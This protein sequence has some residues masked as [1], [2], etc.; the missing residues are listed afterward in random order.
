MK[1]VLAVAISMAL[2]APAL[3]VAQQGLPEQ[4]Q[5]EVANQK[6]SK[7]KPLL[8]PTIDVIGQ[9]LFPYQEGI[10]IDEQYV[11]SQAK[12]NGDISTLLRIN[13]SVQFS[14]RAQTSANMGEIRPADI[15]INGGLFYQNNFRID[16]V[17]FSND[18]DPKND[19]PQHFSD[20]PSDAQGMALDTDL[21][22]NL[23]VYDSNV[24]AR[25]G[26]FNGGVVDVTTRK[27][28]DGFS[29][30]FSWRASRSV[31]NEYHI[32]DSELA[33]FELS[34][35]QGSQPVYDKQK[36]ALTLENRFANGLGLI[37]SVSRL[38]SEIPLRGY[39]S[40]YVPN[41]DETIK[42]NTRENTQYSLRADWDIGSLWNLDFSLNYAPSDE[43]YFIKNTRN[44]WF[45]LSRG[46][47]ATRFSARRSGPVWR[48]NQKLSLSQLDSSRDSRGV[49]TWKTW[50][51]SADKNWGTPGGKQSLEGNWGSVDQTSRNTEYSLDIEREP[52]ALGN[53]RHHL[54]FGFSAAQRSGSYHRLHDHH[55]YTKG[56]A[57]T[58]CTDANGVVDN[59]A[60]SL[61]AVPQFKG[62][63]QYMT[64]YD[65][66]RAGYFKAEADNVS[67]YAEDDIRW[68]NWS[69][70]AGLRLD[71]DSLSKQWTLAPRLA[72]SWD[73]FGDARTLLTGGLNRYYGRN[74][75]A[76]KLREGREALN[77]EYK[78]KNTGADA[79]IWQLEKTPL[80]KG[81]FRD[82]DVPYSDELALGINQ[83]WAGLDI[84]FK[85]VE[86]RNRDEVM[87]QLLNEPGLDRLAYTYVNA[88][89][90]NARTL[91]LSVSNRQPW[92]WGMASTTAMLA[93]DR[94]RVQR[95]YSTTGR[96]DYETTLGD[97]FLGTTV[98]YR[99]ELMRIEE[100]PARD[101]NR[102]WTMRL[103]TQ[104]RFG[105]SGLMLSNFLR[106]RSG[107]QRLVEL[108]REVHG[109]QIIRVYDRELLPRSFTWDATLQ[110]QIPT[111]S[112]FRPYI[113][114]EAMNLL[115]RANPIA[116]SGS[117]YV[118]EPGRN[119]WL[120]LGV[121]F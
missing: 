64:V 71:H 16:G 11:Q 100:I 36:Y 112:Q 30:K 35:D 94:T 56:A 75:F 7:D 88:G 19:N 90:S 15:S 101:F 25:F 114:V 42:T 44:S 24:P 74:L 13:P 66:Y 107:Y 104:T 78:R 39:A 52:F 4:K 65:I 111:G 54:Q 83:A 92:Q 26:G 86:R 18:L 28:S 80:G 116:V 40:G 113:R 49:D 105:D 82:I 103:A 99:G 8:M 106:Y 77:V 81:H 115:N 79:L 31:W 85:A 47:Y 63:G 89:R 117:H 1:S 110:Y 37:A 55:A 5:D 96:S 119:Y 120:E 109:N 41:G 97:G 70:R 61:G 98:R 27:A 93:V 60:C 108:P 53:T 87:R 9:R 48:I 102:P 91:T 50:V 34:S 84:N 62:R 43:A 72:A 46:G 38:R 14:E 68:G 57:T 76:Y 118:Y 59:V 95:N 20:P 21:I 10:S 73:V 69:V 3:A 23:T 121:K 2:F 51:F 6:K 22:G 17:S 12:G 58:S 33:K 67:L 45:D 32:A 29:G